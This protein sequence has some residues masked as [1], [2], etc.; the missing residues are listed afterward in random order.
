MARRFCFALTSFVIVASSHSAPPGV[1]SGAYGNAVAH[2][3]Y[4]LNLQPPEESTH[5]VE[6]SLDAIMKVE[7]EKRTM[8]DSDFAAAKQR[9]V[10]VEKQRIH[11]IVREAFEAR[12]AVSA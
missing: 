2:S 4:T 8:S 5:D 10:N 3:E 11:D 12:A 7:D 6:A 1:V 9:M